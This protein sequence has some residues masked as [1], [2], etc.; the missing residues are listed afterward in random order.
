M[1]VVFRKNLRPEVKFAALHEISGLLLGH[2]VLIRDGYQFLVTKTLG[3]SNVREVWIASLAEATN[4][5]RII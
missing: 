4:N 3:I 2:R 1:E 5:E